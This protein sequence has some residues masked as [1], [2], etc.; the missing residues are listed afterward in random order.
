[1]FEKEP[2]ANGAD[3]IYFKQLRM[4]AQNGYMNA[5]NLYNQAMSKGVKI[6]TVDGGMDFLVKNH[7]PDMI[8]TLDEA[9]G[10]GNAE[11]N[12]NP[13]IPQL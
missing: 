4:L 9:E 13:F 3:V 10:V 5:V 8:E 1:M 2:P 6:V 12:K 7:N 11:L